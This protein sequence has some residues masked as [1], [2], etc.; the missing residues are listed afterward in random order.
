MFD[1][2]NKAELEI[3]DGI[4]DIFGCSFMDA[5]VPVIT[6]FGSA[7]WMWIAMGLVFVF[8][9]KYRRT[10]ITLLAGLVVHLLTCN[11]A[12]KNIVCRD[13]P[14]WVNDS[15]ELLVSNPT[16][17]SFPSGHTMVSFV[18]ATVLTMLHPKWGFWAYPVAALLG[19]SRLYLYVHFPTDVLA[20]AI[21]GVIVGIPVTV[22]MKKLFAYLEKKH[23]ICLQ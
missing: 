9:R 2:L 22:G 12:L 8:I 6:F 14:C 17:Y 10:G 23:G 7:G 21:L 11:I 15:V 1:W 16:D 5:V 19:F 18:A 3:L 20:G 4:Q 13:R